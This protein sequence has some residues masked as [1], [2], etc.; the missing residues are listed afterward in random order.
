MMIHHRPIKKFGT[1]GQIADEKYIPSSR[2][3]CERLIIQSMRDSGYIPVLDVNPQWTMHYD[4]NNNCFDFEISIYGVYC[5][6]RKA[7]K[8]QG[9]IDGKLIPI[10]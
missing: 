7:K 8:Y 1:S 2:I 6:Y 3:E 10:P 9:V 5:G 4:W